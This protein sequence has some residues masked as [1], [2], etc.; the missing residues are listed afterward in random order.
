MCITFA[1]NMRLMETTSKSSKSMDWILFLLSLI[2]TIL[3]LI[4]VT[5][6]FW[7]S[8]PFLITYLVKALDSM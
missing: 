8:L 2:V 7:V 3:L 1:T 4:F 5:E 6:W